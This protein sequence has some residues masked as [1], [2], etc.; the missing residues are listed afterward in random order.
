MRECVAAFV[1]KNGKILLGRR[2]ATREFYPDVWDAFGGHQK[3]GESDEQTLRRELMEEL[4]I[5]PTIWKFLITVDEPNPLEN[6]E[7][8]YHFYLITDFTGE[9]RN[10][11]PAEH[12]F[13][14]W[15]SFEEALQLEFAD[16]LYA[17]MIRQIAG[18]F[19]FYE[20]G[21]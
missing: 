21:Y 15:F 14:E 13:I 10:L 3:A 12:A 7:G 2:S 19:V 16:P 9:A 5:V 18:E 17:E 20:R 6:G 11:Q 1:V 4:G 8:N